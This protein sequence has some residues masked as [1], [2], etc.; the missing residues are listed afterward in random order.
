MRYCSVLPSLARNGGQFL[1]KLKLRCFQIAKRESPDDAPYETSTTC[2][3]SQGG[4]TK[5]IGSPCSEQTRSLHS[6]EASEHDSKDLDL[7]DAHSPVIIKD[8]TNDH[9]D[10]HDSQQKHQGSSIQRDSLAETVGH[11]AATKYPNNR[12]RQQQQN[13]DNTDAS[14]TS[15]SPS[16][17]E[18]ST[19]QRMSETVNP[20]SP[21]ELTS[22]AAVLDGSQ[23]SA[24]MVSPYVEQHHNHLQ[25]QLQHPDDPGSIICLNSEIR[26][27]NQTVHSPTSGSSNS[28]LWVPD[29]TSVSNFGINSSTAYHQSQTSI[30]PAHDFFTSVVPSSQTSVLQTVHEEDIALATHGYQLRYPSQAPPGYYHQ[31]PAI[32]R[33]SKYSPFEYPKY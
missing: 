6:K 16:H 25:R 2:G 11:T 10:D 9:M 28:S 4:S 7:D 3:N 29:L 17:C 30:Y 31:Y 19:A 20:S 26:S 33:P 1:M 23:E 24:I 32:P 13:H 18:M 5:E 8:S 22:P 21:N 12:Y 27:Q 14:D 15:E